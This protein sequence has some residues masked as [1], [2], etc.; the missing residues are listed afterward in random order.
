MLRIRH[1]AVGAAVGFFAA[2]VTLYLPGLLGRESICA[3]L[4]ASIHWPV[5]RIV[6]RLTDTYF[7]DNRDGGLLFWLPVHFGYWMC[8][9]TLVGAL[10]SLGSCS[11]RGGETKPHGND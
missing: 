10:Y 5:V 9:G 8:W 1:L 7:H 2:V 6:E 4:Y 3:K 11:W